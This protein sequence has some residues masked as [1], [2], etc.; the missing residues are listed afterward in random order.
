MRITRLAFTL[1]ELLV[2][3]TV[4]VIMAGLL[5]PVFKSAEDR[6]RQTQCMSNFHSVSLATG[7]YMEDYDDYFPPVNY[8][9]AEE[10]NSRNDRTWVQMVLPYLRS[11]EVF[12]CPSSPTTSLTPEATFDRDLVPGDTF[13]RF[14]TASLH[15]SVGY[16][17]Q[18]LSPIVKVAGQW[19]SEPRS[20]SM[21]AKPSSTV[22]F[23]DSVWD[24]SSD[25]T[26]F[27][28][29]SWLVVPPCRYYV[30]S[31]MP[32]QRIDSFTM[33]VAST[34]EVFTTT[35]G[36]DLTGLRTPSLYGGVWARHNGRATVAKADGS[37]HA[38]SV[39]ELATGCELKDRWQGVIRDIDTYSWDIR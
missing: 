30:D 17:F 6:A 32:S 2:V 8:Q 14:Y 19:T 36:W 23:V 18:Y 34:S 24:R 11:F 26:P 3:L 10:P 27:G 29:G 33:T 13:S 35:E 16:N 37:V 7:L 20:G 4:M 21:L 9:P 25:G 31:T 28:G 1:I 38:Q 15:S 39:N 22:V 12:R 5:F